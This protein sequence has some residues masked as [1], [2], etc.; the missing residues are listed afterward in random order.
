MTEQAN[1]M[2]SFEF[3]T[4]AAAAADPNNML[5]LH[6]KPLEVPLSSTTSESEADALLSPPPEVAAEEGAL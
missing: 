4:R 2:A 5:N 1:L 6:L 3:E